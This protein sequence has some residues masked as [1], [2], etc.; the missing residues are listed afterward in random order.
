[1]LEHSVISRI[2]H[3]LT[4]IHRFEGEELGKT[5]GWKILVME[6]RKSFYFLPDFSSCYLREGKLQKVS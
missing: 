3:Y 4:Q 6:E 1:M 2:L 5:C